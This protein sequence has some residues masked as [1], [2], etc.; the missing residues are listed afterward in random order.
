MALSPCCVPDRIREYQVQ[1]ISDIMTSS[2]WQI[3]EIM[4]IFQIP[5]S[6]TPFYYIRIIGL[7]QRISACDTFFRL[8]QQ[9]LSPEMESFSKILETFSLFLTCLFPFCVQCVSR[10][11]CCRSPKQKQASEGSLREIAAEFPNRP[12]KLEH[13][14]VFWFGTSNDVIE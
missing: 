10:P 12:R 2:L 6:R 3:L 14:M 13:Q 7:W 9:G 11:G 1:R 8:V 5:D 4:T